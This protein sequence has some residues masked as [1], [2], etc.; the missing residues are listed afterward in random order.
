MMAQTPL[1]GFHGRV[2]ELGIVALGLIFFD[3]VSEE[4]KKSD[5][6]H[7][8]SMIEGIDDFTQAKV[9]EGMISP[10]ESERAK[11]L[12]AILRYDMIRDNQESKEVTV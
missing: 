4:C 1:V 7:G 10:E 6:K 2:D 5:G 9:V 11:T 8:M 3:T 12:E